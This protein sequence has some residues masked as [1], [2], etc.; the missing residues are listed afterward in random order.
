MKETPGEG[1]GVK[2]EPYGYILELA[3]TAPLPITQMWSW[4]SLTIR[5]NIMAGE[6]CVYIS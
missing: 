4:D 6:S 3:E 1:T 5:V 2:L